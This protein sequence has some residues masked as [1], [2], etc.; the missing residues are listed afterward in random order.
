MERE[1]K[2]LLYNE[3]L[4]YSA[5]GN[6]TQ[7]DASSVLNLPHFKVQVSLHLNPIDF[8]GDT[9]TL[10]LHETLMTWVRFVQLRCN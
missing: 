2:Q 4:L 3:P 8:N 5:A 10:T 9:W 1:K 7:Q 6:I